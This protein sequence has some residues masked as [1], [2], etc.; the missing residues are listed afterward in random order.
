M[1]V[2]VACEYSGRVRDAFIERGHEATSCDILPSDT[3]G[4][5]Y[6]GDVRD[7]L[8]DGWD[9]LIAF[10]PC[11]DLS[12]IGA[13][14]WP[15]KQADGRQ[16]RALDFVRLLMDAPVPRTAVENP[17]GRINTAIRR[18]DQII[19]P[20]MFGD[21]WTKRTCLW[22]RGLPLLEPTNAVEPNGFWV[23]GGSKKDGRSLS[24]EGA[25]QNRTGSDKWADIAHDRNKTFQGIADAMADQWGSLKLG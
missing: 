6:Q 15:Q 16:Q 12:S 22:L 3:P 1:K 25:R 11:T 18:P 19:Q 5:H 20:W 8:D 9:M 4:S 13:A 24:G 21:P 17:V 7:I 14:Y 10:P 23:G 2:L